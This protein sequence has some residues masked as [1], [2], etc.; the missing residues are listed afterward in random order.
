M[1]TSFQRQESGI[2]SKCNWKSVDGFNKG[3]DII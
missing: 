1:E 2:H 3:S